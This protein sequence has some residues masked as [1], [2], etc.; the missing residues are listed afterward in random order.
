MR[1][2]IIKMSYTGDKIE[3]QG[4]GAA[5]HEQIHLIQEQCQDEFKVLVNKRRQHD[6]LHVHTIDPKGFI[7][8]NTTKAPVVMHVHFLPETLEGSIKLPKPIM[9]LFYKYFLSM[10][11]KADAIVVVNPIFIEALSKYGIEKEKIHY[12]PNFVSEETFYSGD[13]EARARLRQNYGIT[14]DKFV[15]IGVGQVQTRKGVLD[16]IEVAKALP[17]IQFVWV[18]GFSF[19]AITDGYKELKAVIDNPPANVIFTDIVPR[20]EMNAYYN[21]GDLLF[22]PSYNELFPMALLEACSSGMPLL[23]RDLDLYEVI[24]F[25]D[26]AKAHDNQGFIEW[27]KTLSE[28]K[29]TYK[30]QK[31]VSRRISNYYSRQ[32][33]R[34]QWIAFYRSLVKD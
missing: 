12:I 13:T 29:D 19:G 15:V 8:M 23:L 5:T 25:E 6:I 33:V 7:R 17:D 21:M 31:E 18:G 32:H 14:E 34:K 2:L 24:L 1:K 9:K 20:T 22:M 4:V 16:F 28:S 26:Y 27:I 11:R 10:Y 3:G 30:T